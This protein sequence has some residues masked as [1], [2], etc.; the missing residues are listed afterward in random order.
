M[1]DTHQQML[2][3]IP[4][5]SLLDRVFLFIYATLFT[6][7]FMAIGWREINP[8]GF[9][10]LDNYRAGFQSSIYLYHTLDL[11]IIEFFLAEATWVR[12]FDALY[13]YLNDIDLAFATVT[14]TSVFLLSAYVIRRTGSVVPLIFFMNPGFIDMVVGQIRSGLAAGLFFTAVNIRSL[15]IKVALILLASSLHTSFLLL[16]LFYLGFYLLKR[17]GPLDLTIVRPYAVMALLAVAAVVVTLFRDVL[18]ASVG[19]SRGFDVLTYQSRVFLTLGF[20]SFSLSYALLSRDKSLTFE[21]A[22]YLFNMVMALAGAI[23]GVYGSR[24]VAYGIPVLAVMAASLPVERRVPF[25]LQYA[26][27]SALY[28]TYWI[29]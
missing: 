9:D 29:V 19:D 16:G 23:I 13:E 26:V 27:F 18:L 25:Y 28:F 10:D 11:S 3:G 2:H 6:T 17:V 24:F 14:A 7:G 15:W 12:G 8:Y 1:Q 20:L 5:R 22:F 21:A 4:K